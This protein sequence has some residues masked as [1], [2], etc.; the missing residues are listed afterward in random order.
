MAAH[1]AELS[2]GIERG[3]DV[4]RFGARWLRIALLLF[5]IYMVAFADR[6]NIS[7]AVPALA[8]DLGLSATI[9]GLLLS[10]FFWGYLATMVPGGWLA[11]RAGATKIIVTASAVLGVATMACAFSHNLAAL[12]V[13]RV[14]MGLAEGVLFPAFTVIYLQWFPASERGQAVNSCELAIPLASV[15]SA[16]LAGWLIEHFDWPRMFL[17]QGAPMLVLA[18]VFLVLGSDSPEQDRWISGAEREHILQTRSGQTTTEGTFR[19]VLASPRVWVQCVVYFGWLAGLYG[20]GLWLPSSLKSM[21]GLGI[22][23]VGW[24]SAVPY[25]CAFVCMYFCARWSDRSGRSRALFVIVPV[26]VAG[27]ALVG[28]HYAHPGALVQFLLMTVACM[29][30]YAGLGPWWTWSIENSPRNHAGAAIGL[31]NVAGNLGG[32]IGP[33][34]VGAVSASASNVNGFYVLGFFAI[35]S[36]LLLTTQLRTDRRRAGAGSA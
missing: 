26:L 35:A 12:I 21:S 7:V 11:A 28:G 24:L 14:V 29:G 5:L 32:V 20:F 8:H 18:V 30:I 15:V 25:L 19:A 3:T 6:T 33:V 16:P 2:P 34:V 22:E 9:T 4:P 36:G 1:R 13:C 17:V 31:I 23:T 10:A 27:V